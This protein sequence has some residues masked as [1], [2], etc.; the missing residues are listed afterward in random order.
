[1]SRRKIISSPY[2]TLLC[3][4]W[5]TPVYAYHRRQKR[6]KTRPDDLHYGA[7]CASC[8][9][10]ILQNL[11]H[12]P[13]PVSKLKLVWGIIYVSNQTISPIITSY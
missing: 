4:F 3:R 11:V 7:L 10:F 13:E 12:L 1:M 5:P 6:H 2:V 9:K 8:S